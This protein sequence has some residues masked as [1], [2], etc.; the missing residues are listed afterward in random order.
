VEEII[1]KP[2]QNTDNKW[3]KTQL[4]KEWGSVDIVTRGKIINVAKLPGLKAI[5]GNQNAGFVAYK[6]N[7][8]EC[9]IVALKSLVEGK[10]VGTKLLDEVIRIAK[11]SNCRRIWLITTND[12]IKA[13]R[14]YQKRGFRLSAI[15][16]NALDQSR[17]LKPEIPEIGID[18]IPLRDEIEVEMKLI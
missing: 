9:E 5:F 11:E 13:L 3:V 10:G 17:K 7:N 1:I 6:I 8:T 18:G 12:N 4:E 15:Y 2:L 14:F 16:P